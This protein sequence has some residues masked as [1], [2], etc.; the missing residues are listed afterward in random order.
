MVGIPQDTIFINA[1]WFKNLMIFMLFS[2]ASASK[3]GPVV[4]HRPLPHDLGA[5]IF[6]IPP[7]TVSCEAMVKH[8]KAAK[9]VFVHRRTH[10]GTEAQLCTSLPGQMGCCASQNLHSHAAAL[11]A[12]P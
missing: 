9:L 12:G 8:C 5:G 10:S 11:T 3:C 4:A 7:S 2:R 1:L 6:Y